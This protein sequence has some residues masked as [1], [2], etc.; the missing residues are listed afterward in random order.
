MFW[1]NLLS[2]CRSTTLI[3]KKEKTLLKVILHGKA[4]DDKK[5]IVLETRNINTAKEFLAQKYPDY[6]YKIVSRIIR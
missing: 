5:V 4:A 2:E 6:E 1:M 3:F